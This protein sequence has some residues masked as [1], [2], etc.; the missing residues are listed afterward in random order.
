MS[1]FE[2]IINQLWSAQILE[3]M[4]LFGCTHQDLSSDVTGTANK[5]SE[6]V[7]YRTRSKFY[8]FANAT[9]YALK[10]PWKT[11]YIHLKLSP[12]RNLESLFLEIPSESLDSVDSKSVL[13]F[14]IG[15][16]I[17]WFIT[18]Y[19]LRIA[20]PIFFLGHPVYAVAESGKLTSSKRSKKSQ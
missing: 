1:Q 11:P 8:G 20:N 18:I 5:T 17:S 19:K 9:Q 16:K 15:P 10:H 13:V 7:S 2:I 6:K 3:R 12:T 4:T 14:L